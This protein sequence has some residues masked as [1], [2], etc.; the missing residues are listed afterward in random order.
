LES[1]EANSNRLQLTPIGVQYTST[2]LYSNIPLGI[3][4]GVEIGI[5]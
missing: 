5:E 2:P 3:G 1:V 4:V